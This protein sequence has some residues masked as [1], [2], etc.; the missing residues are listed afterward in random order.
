M[1]DSSFRS[2]HIQYVDCRH[3]GSPGAR[4]GNNKE[5][6]EGQRGLWGGRR[7]PAGGRVEPCGDDPG[8]QL[9][10]E[11]AGQDAAAPEMRGGTSAFSP[12]PRPSVQEVR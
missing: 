12:G 2:G 3:Q 11:W 6:L 9:E 7:L 10:G 1:L 8:P 4:L 5:L